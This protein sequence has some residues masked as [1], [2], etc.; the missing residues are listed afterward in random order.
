[1][2]S[3]Q[4]FKAVW[5]LGLTLS[6][7]WWLRIDRQASATSTEE[8][9]CSSNR[10][11]ASTETIEPVRCDVEANGKERYGVVQAI[12]PH[13]HP[14]AKRSADLDRTTDE[15][16]IMWFPVSLYSKWNSREKLNY[17]PEFSLL[18]M[19]SALLSTC[20][21]EHNVFL[22][23]MSC[24]TLK[25]AYNDHGLIS[26]DLCNRTV[27]VPWMWH[28]LCCERLLK[29]VG[30]SNFQYNLWWSSEINRFRRK[31]QIIHSSIS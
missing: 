22:W 19:K 26:C 9:P 3:L 2:E 28:R 17:S 21:L 8:T 23:V 7:C 24:L 30:F 18:L 5:F 4:T 25:N 10:L 1:M 6:C 29:G 16:T 15:G 13:L 11:P 14:G 20:T 31:L 12:P 27:K